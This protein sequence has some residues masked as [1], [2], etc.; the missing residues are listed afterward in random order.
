MCLV[1]GGAAAMVRCENAIGD[2]G[3]R[4]KGAQEAQRRTRQGI[5]RHVMCPI[6]QSRA[7]V[8]PSPPCNPLTIK[9]TI[10]AKVKVATFGSC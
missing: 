3:A 10:L 9:L 1:R 5:K 8:Q 4:R 2:S 6:M 7:L